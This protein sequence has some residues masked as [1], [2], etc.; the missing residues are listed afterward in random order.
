MQ[1]A[2]TSQNTTQSD[3]NHLSDTGTYM[4]DDASIGTMGDIGL[5]TNPFISRFTDPI[6]LTDAARDLADMQ[7]A[8]MVRSLREAASLDSALVAYVQALDGMTRTQMQASLDAIISRWAGTS[9]Q[10]TAIAAAEEE[11]F[12]LV[13][14]PPGTSLSD[15]WA[16]RRLDDAATATA[17]A[18]SNPTEFARLQALK[19]QQETLSAQIGVLERFNAQPF[20]TVRDDSVTTGQGAVILAQTGAQLD[21]GAATGRYV[22]VSLN[23]GQTPLLAQAYAALKQSVYDA[24][25]PQTRL[26]PHLDSIRLSIDTNGF[27]LDCSALDLTLDARYAADKMRA[28]TDYLELRQYGQVISAD[29][30][31]HLVSRFGGWAKRAF[32]DVRYLAHLHERGLRLVRHRGA[33][34]DRR[35]WR[36]G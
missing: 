2:R 24:L 36:S 8:G 14:L 31:P 16:I 21:G 12:K 29:F 27:R 19:E 9:S 5:V 6:V 25:A 32:D 11:G 4:R 7:G 1:L 20:V 17:L 26:R 18:T 30:A 23:T 34:D 35:N 22:V 3:G 28:L 15:Y 10:K 33:N 13:Y